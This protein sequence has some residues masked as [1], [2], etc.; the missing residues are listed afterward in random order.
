MAASWQDGPSPPAAGD[1]AEIIYRLRA[2][3]RS[4]PQAASLAGFPSTSGGAGDAARSHPHPHDRRPHGPVRVRAIRISCRQS[5]HG[6]KCGLRHDEQSLVERGPRVRPKRW[7]G[8]VTDCDLISGRVRGAPRRLR[9]VPTTGRVHAGGRR[10]QLIR[11]RMRCRMLALMD[12]EIRANLGR[13]VRTGVDA[14]GWRWEITRGAEV[15]QVIIEISGRAWSCDPLSLP[16]DTRHALETDGPCRATQGPRPGR[17]AP[18]HPMRLFRLLVS[19]CRRT[20]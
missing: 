13:H 9:S 6:R 2:I 18:R 17:P 5:R 11:R 4:S 8:S 10:A 12:W 19:V 7:R 20:R 16:E 1:G 14:H 15:S 3:E